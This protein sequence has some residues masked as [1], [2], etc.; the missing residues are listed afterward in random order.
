MTEPTTPPST[1]EAVREALHPFLLEYA[2]VLPVSFE[3]EAA[4]AA[5]DAYYAH[6]EPWLLDILEWVHAQGS[7]NTTRRLLRA[8]PG[9][10]RKAAGL[11]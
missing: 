8:V 1:F 6:P 4:Q 9:P 10:L 5:L 11:S 2:S 7:T 3:E